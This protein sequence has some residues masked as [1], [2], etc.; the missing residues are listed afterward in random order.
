VTTTLTVIMIAV[1]VLAIIWAAGLA[2]REE[3]R[4]GDQRRHPGGVQGRL[5]DEALVNAPALLLLVVVLTD[6]L[7]PVSG[8]GETALYVGVI[9]VML[10]FI[11]LPPVRAARARLAALRPKAPAQ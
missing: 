4:A 9:V 5:L 2:V 6:D 10:G 7:L 8:W 1:V 3:G 11:F